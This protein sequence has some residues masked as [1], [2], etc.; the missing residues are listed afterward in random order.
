MKLPYLV[1]FLFAILPFN[2]SA[3]E[4][5]NIGDPGTAGHGY[6]GIVF[7]ELM[8]VSDYV[9]VA[10]RAYDVAERNAKALSEDIG[11]LL[12]MPS[13]ASLNATRE[14]WKK[15]HFSYAQTEVYRFA[16][17]EVDLW[18]GRVNA[19]PV[20]ESFIDYVAT[21]FAAGVSPINII[22]N[23][24]LTA[25]GKK[26]DADKIDVG[27]IRSLHE[28]GGN[29]ANIAGGYHAIE[30]LLWGQDLNGT[31]NGAG[32]RTHLDYSLSDCAHVPCERR[33]EYLQAVVQLLVSDLNEMKESLRSGEAS[34]RLLN[35]NP[36]QILTTA[37][38]GMIGLSI[39]ELAGERL[40]LAL[41]SGDPEETHNCFSDTTHSALINNQTG[42]L[43]VYTSGSNQLTVQNMV[44]AADPALDEAVVESFEHTSA[45]LKQLEEK[46]QSGETLDTLIGRENED[47][48]Q[49]VRELVAAFI[50]QGTALSNAAAALN[51][52]LH[53]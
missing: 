43:R 40:K 22:A 11:Q 24:T 51:I 17:P 35:S 41:L 25:Y 10:I 44:K 31:N 13:A 47:G 52:D 42:I 50:R 37:F 4:G 21:P 16:N 28:L 39:I 30:F 34:V 18:E 8:F 53:Q 6:S 38:K 48:N 12:A 46:A 26:I 19:W 49:L 9:S 14:G 15:A 20:D 5:S 2:L 36:E 32:M 27:L 7:S 1:L 3:D 45:L 23:P 29:E 33:R